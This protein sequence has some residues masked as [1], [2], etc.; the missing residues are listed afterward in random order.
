MIFQLLLA[1]ITFAAVALLVYSVFGY[2]AAIE[3]PAHRRVAAALG[4]DRDTIFDKPQYR[5]VLAL[6]LELARRVGLSS[7]RKELDRDLAASGNPSGYSVDEYL[8]LCLLSG[9]GLGVLGG[10]LDLALGGATGVVTVPVL[11]AMGLAV[12]VFVLRGAARSRLRRIGQQLPYSL[13]LIALVVE[14]GASFNEAIETLIRDE[15]DDELNQE[16][17][18]VLSEMELG[19]P[20]AQALANLAER[21]PLE[22]LRS[23]VAAVSQ[24]DRL[25]TPLSSI[26]KLQAEMMRQQ[27]SVRAEKLSASASL[28]ILIPSMLILLAVVAIVFSPFIIRAIRGELF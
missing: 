17:G 23:V 26:L 14:A 10:L 8:A 16:L 11:F 2:R 3:A 27:R 7:L 25:G 18:V 13:D 1:L 5:P 20:R 6:A 19:T 12:P 28:R 4:R 22:S 9:V 15:P 21:L 24:A